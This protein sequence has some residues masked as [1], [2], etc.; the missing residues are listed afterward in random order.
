MIGGIIADVFSA[1]DRGLAISLYT[2]APFIGPTLGP[3]I[4]GFLGENAG[5]VWVQGFLATFA[6]VI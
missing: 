6:G 2:G 5:W 3:V 4:G 1:E